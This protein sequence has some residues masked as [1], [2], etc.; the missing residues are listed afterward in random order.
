MSRRLHNAFMDRKIRLY[1]VMDDVTDI[2]QSVVVE[3]DISGAKVEVTLGNKKARQ[4]YALRPARGERESG[5]IIPVI[6]NQEL[7]PLLGHKERLEASPNARL[8]SPS[9][10]VS[11]DFGGFDPASVAFQSL[12][13]AD[14]NATISTPAGTVQ[15]NALTAGLAAWGNSGAVTVATLTGWTEKYDFDTFDGS[16]D[17]N[18]ACQHRLASA[19]PPASST[20]VFTGADFWKGGGIIRWSGNDTTTEVEAGNGQADSGAT[21]NYTTPTI[22]A[23]A[24]SGTFVT[25]T[26]SASP[27]TPAG[28]TLAWSIDGGDVES[29]YENLVGADATLEQIASNGGSANWVAGIVS[30]KPLAVGGNAMPMAAHHYK[31]RRAA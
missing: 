5:L 11:I 3:N 28:M 14:D 22:A 27:A 24:G 1:L 2:L 16:S 9:L 25:V 10:N 8:L 6:T 19:S 12:T 18:A 15:N 13:S 31:M 29:Y 23:S 4:D 20:W 7:R 30:V 21:A 26:N 17:F